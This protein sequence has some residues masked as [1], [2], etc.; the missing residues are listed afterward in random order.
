VNGTFWLAYRIRRP[1]DSGRGVGVVVAKSVD[2]VNFKPVA[3]VSREAFGAA[4][5]ERPAIL[6]TDAGWRLYLS[7]A[8]PNSAPGRRTRSDDLHLMGNLWTR[9]K[10]GAPLWENRP[11]GAAYYL[12]AK[13]C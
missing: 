2:G 11:S 5:L 13:E 6:P 1:L 9:P 4:S 8:T 10:A 7:C 3:A 12:A